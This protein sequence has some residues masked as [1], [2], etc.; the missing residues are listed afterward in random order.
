MPKVRSKSNIK[1]FEGKVFLQEGPISL[2]QKSGVMTYS[3]KKLDI[4]DQLSHSFFYDEWNHKS[5][6]DNTD[7]NPYNDNR[8]INFLQSSEVL[9]S[10]QVEEK[11]F[12]SG[13]L[14][15]N[16]NKLLSTPNTIPGLGQTIEHVTSV[17]N[18]AIHDRMLNENYLETKKSSYDENV[19]LLKTSSIK[20]GDKYHTITIDYDLHK[21]NNSDLYLSFSKKGDTREITFPDNTSYYSF[22][23]NTAYFYNPKY[24]KNNFGPYDYLGNVS[25]DYKSSLENFLTKSPICFNG[26]SVYES[27]L[28]DTKSKFGSIP[29]HNF[30][31]PFNSKFKAQE[32]HKIKASDYINKPF[33]LEKVCLEFTMSNWSVMNTTNQIA[34][35]P[36]V[37]FVNFFLLNQKDSL[38]KETLK[39]SIKT[40]YLGNSNNLLNY[41]IP[42]DYSNDTVYTTN[43]KQNNNTYS[44]GDIQ[45]MSLH[46]S[47]LGD[48][49]HESS[50]I[51]NNL[52]QGIDEIENQTQQR[53]IIT[54]ITVTNY[55][56]WGNPD[57]YK[58]NYNKL[59]NISDIVMDWTQRQKQDED[60]V[61][62]IIYTN[63]KIKVEAPIKNFYQNKNLPKMSSFKI[64]PEKT[65]SDKTNLDTNS[66]RSIP[67][68]LL[69]NLESKETIQV[70]NLDVLINEND[71][72]EGNYILL[73]SDELILG[74]SLS[75]GFSTQEDYN[76]PSNQLRF[77]ED[78]VK[79]SSSEE[80]P[81][82][83]HLIGYYLEDDKEKILK[84]KTVK[85]YR[86]SKRVGYSFNEIHDNHGSNLGYLENN[87]YDYW[88]KDATRNTSL[89]GFTLNNSYRQDE[90]VY[91]NYNKTRLGNFSE[92]PNLSVG[93]YIKDTGIKYYESG[94]SS[95]LFTFHDT[96]MSKI[97]SEIY[98]EKESED[99]RLYKHFYNKYHFG[100]FFDRMN[101]NRIH[102]FDDS[103]YFNVNK[104][105]MLGFFKQK[106]P[107]TISGKIKFDFSKLDTFKGNN[108][109][110]E[111][112]MTSSNGKSSGT[113]ILNVSIKDNKY[114]EV[115]IMFL[116][117]EDLYN[118]DVRF[119][120]VSDYYFDNNGKETL[121]VHI[122]NS[123]VSGFEKSASSN[124]DYEIVYPSD[125]QIQKREFVNLFVRGINE[126]ND[127]TPQIY[128]SSLSNSGID[129]DFKI[130]I[131]AEVLN[132]TL[133]SDI[134]EVKISLNSK[135]LSNNETIYKDDI[136]SG[137]LIENFSIE[138]GHLIN[139]YNIHKN[140]YY[141][142]SELL[143]KDV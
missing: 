47:V 3:N 88:F 100:F 28:D 27:L 66:C 111:Y 10:F 2:C 142:N 133:S 53:D 16:Q 94:N 46:G 98:K 73:P 45:D 124:F 19:D 74:V 63:E 52:I 123:I 87:F 117:K 57:S 65:S 60:N 112:I 23:G 61:S 103:D 101:H 104:R 106:T 29:I 11:Y 128:Y 5:K 131:V 75:N 59:L 6:F 42:V 79:I 22:N 137:V 9:P 85:S 110:K 108:Y 36:C 1:G 58:L 40:N 37:N 43:N 121:I 13:T 129:K 14:F 50:F 17:L 127:S 70:N 125:L 95:P 82:K 126:I 141:N 4:D 113:S 67:G 143:F 134:V 136:N 21:S 48:S 140:A 32:R 91:S 69:N 71:Y 116:A 97:N 35:L 83:L 56:N 31:F 44:E 84:N 115:N 68:E 25:E 109:L 130:D 76:I 99:F 118:N 39:S 132:E 78:L 12:K 96:I 38:N 122:P 33:V 89:D 77:G 139:S 49:V 34:Q 64:L 92:I 55:S 135:G 114:N 51:K 80:Y 8:T 90:Y 93:K 18:P 41:N 62:E 105:F 138:E 24:I 30:G 86:N 72:K 26:I 102:Q 20:G 120:S 119:E 15:N 81:F 54:T 7:F 107:A